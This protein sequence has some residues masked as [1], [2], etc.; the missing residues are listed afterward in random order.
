MAEDEQMF[1]KKISTKLQTAKP[2]TKKKDILTDIKFVVSYMS[3]FF[4]MMMAALLKDTQRRLYV[5]S[6]GCKNSISQSWKL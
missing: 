2:S 6:G 1:K 3:Y 4:N 5:S